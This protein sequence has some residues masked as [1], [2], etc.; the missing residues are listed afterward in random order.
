[1][2]KDCKFLNVDLELRS[3]A[4]L[5]PLVEA[6]KPAC[7]VL[8]HIPG[9]TNIANLEV[10]VDFESA[11]PDDYIMGFCDLI[12]H[13]PERARVIWNSSERIFDVG[14]ESGNSS[15]RLKFGIQPGTIDR[16]ARLGASIAVT[17][18]PVAKD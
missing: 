3:P 1:M 14:L 18:Y 2:S 16:V 7:L 9:D 11:T 13:L 5:T 4:D 6:L 12:E 17:L 10:D 15:E 8:A